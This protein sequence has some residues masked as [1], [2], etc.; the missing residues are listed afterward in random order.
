VVVRRL[1]LPRIRSCWTVRLLQDLLCGLGPDE[2]VDAVVP[3]VDEG[4]DFGVEVLD[5]RE[6]APSA[7]LALDDAEPDLDQVHPGGV[8]GSE[9]DLEPGFFLEPRTDVPVLVGGVVVHRQMPLDRVTSLV[10]DVA[11]GP[12]DLLEERQAL[13]LSV[14]RLERGGDLPGGHVESCEQGRGAVLV[15]VVGRRSIR[16][17]RIGRIGTVRSKA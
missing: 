12:L 11:V 16:P 6:H 3:A 8:G 17:S 7:G 1:L 13:L 9:V 14:P 4:S 2:G 15:V 5:G 10:D